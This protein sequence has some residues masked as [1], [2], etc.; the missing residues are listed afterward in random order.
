MTTALDVARRPSTVNDL[1]LALVEPAET[2][3]ESAASGA[4]SRELEQGVWD[5]VLGLGRRLLEACLAT[6]CQ[7]ATEQD[8]EA[9]QLS[10]GTVRMRFDADY[11]TTQ[12]S[13]F[14]PVTFP[15][16][17]YREVSGAATVTRTPARTNVVPTVGRCRSTAL[18]LEWEARLA[19]DLPFREAQAAMTFFTHG[20]VE[21]EDTT[22]AAHAVAIGQVIDRRW[23]FR[24][25][26]QIRALLADRATR[27]KQ[28]GRPLVY[29]SQDAHAERRY[30]DETWTAAW[31]SLNGIRLWAIDRK[32]GAT[33]HL[34]GE[35]TW[36]DCNAVGRIIDDLIADGVLPMDG[37]YGGGVQ[38][39]LVV[40]TDGL[41]WIED[42]VLAK[43]PWA[44][45]VL[46]MYHALQRLGRF[47]AE[48]CG[49]GKKAAGKLYHRFAK[50][51]APARSRKRMPSA[52]KGHEKGKRRRKPTRRFG[53]IWQL[54]DALYEYGATLDSTEENEALDS[55]LGYL[56]NNAYR[57]DYDSYHARGFQLGS[58]A[59]E[60]FHR[61]AAQLRLK[62]PGA[63]WTA[64]TSLA[65]VNLRL[66]DLAG[67]WDQ[68]WSHPEFNKTARH[69]FGLTSE[70]QP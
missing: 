14:G 53:S 48:I 54:L 42:H 59:M 28:T 56:Q 15:M 37:D 61:S 27:D 45:A 58:G 10:P 32:T 2:L 43:L 1:L 25:V 36:G 12:M 52:R 65:L 7:R 3:M 5:V 49:T 19:K 39:V 62:R 55:L 23:L 29:L 16:F 6:A 64:E 8:I 18:C 22:I 46:D 11:W 44:Q 57:G 47:A 24:P 17:A 67:R 68:F 35:Y 34:G 63:R 4:G 30:V 26:D 70:E 40:V 31:K 33:I 20:A 66:L 60:A 13:T 41:P 9:R 50:L 38:A 51:L 69:A 21:Q